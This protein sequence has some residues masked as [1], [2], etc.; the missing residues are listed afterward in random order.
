[1]IYSGAERGTTKEDPMSPDLRDL[2]ASQQRRLTIVWG[3]FVAATILY[4]VLGVLIARQAPGM[5]AGVSS[6]PIVVGVATCGLAIAGAG[7]AAG[8]RLLTQALQGGKV[9]GAPLPP[10]RLPGR[11]LTE[12]ERYLASRMPAYQAVMII[13]WASYESAGVVGLVLSIMM[14]DLVPAVLGS[15]VAMVLLLSNRPQ[16]EPFISECDRWRRL[17]RRGGDD[18]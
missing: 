17:H 6:L 10:P 11:E 18:L 9:G 3:A 13:T 4:A 7:A 5:A 16:V 1:V 8:R 14:C 12:D 15:A 2:V